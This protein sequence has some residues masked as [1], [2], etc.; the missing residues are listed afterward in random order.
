[1]SYLD[2]I[3]EFRDEEN[4]TPMAL[5]YDVYLI[6]LN[7]T[8]RLITL[9]GEQHVPPDCPGQPYGKLL[10]EKID[11]LA[12][13]GKTPLRDIYFEGGSTDNMMIED[14]D[15]Y[16]SFTTPIYSIRYNF[17]NEI[18]SREYNSKNVRVINIDK[19]GT[20][21]NIFSVFTNYIISIQSSPYPIFYFEQLKIMNKFNSWRE[22]QIVID[23]FLDRD[24]INKHM[25]KIDKETGKS[26]KELYPNIVEILET[27]KWIYNDIVEIENDNVICKMAKKFRDLKNKYSPEVYSS[28]V[29][30]LIDAYAYHRKYFASIVNISPRS[31]FATLEGYHRFCIDLLLKIP[32]Y[33]QKKLIDISDDFTGFTIQIL[34]ILISQEIGDIEMLNYYKKFLND[35]ITVFVKFTSFI[36]EY[37]FITSFLNNDVKFINLIAGNAHVERINKFF[38]GLMSNSATR[39]KVKRKISKDIPPGE[40]V[41]EC[42]YQDIDPDKE[43]F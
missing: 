28:I 43:I 30:S 14:R 27:E 7:G 42:I 32:E 26:Y 36:L 38:E 34:D 3:P 6:D 13:E 5:G 17:W 9:V 4:G 31:I 2:Y 35:I 24:G 33:I 40:T 22:L 37:D 23:C 15:H 19:R 18:N 41:D 12:S 11:K 8:K 25:E 1:M 16:K 29:K 21:N 10:K 39:D 20:H